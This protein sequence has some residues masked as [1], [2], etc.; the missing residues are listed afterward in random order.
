MIIFSCMFDYPKQFDYG[1]SQLVR[2]IDVL[3]HQMVGFYTL[4]EAFTARF[5]LNFKLYATLLLVFK[6]LK[7]CNVNAFF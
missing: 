4:Y 3:Q 7:L 6:R 1:T 2:I 5:K